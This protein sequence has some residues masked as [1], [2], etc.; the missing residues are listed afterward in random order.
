MIKKS[1]ID[2]EM[3]G[4]FLVEISYQVGNNFV[5]ELPTS[6]ISNLKKI[7]SPFLSSCQCTN[8]VECR[9]LTAHDVLPCVFNITI[10]LYFCLNLADDLNFRIQPSSLSVDLLQTAIFTCSATGYNMKY[11]WTIGIG[12]FPSKVTG[13]NTNTLVIPDVR[14]S[15]DNIYTCTISNDGGSVT[16][17]PAKLTVTGMILF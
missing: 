3:A 1:I 2:S 17:N 4:N 9:L 7:A 12:S 5:A 14:S 15:D 16:S 10:V 6:Y 11:Q 8:G 13:I